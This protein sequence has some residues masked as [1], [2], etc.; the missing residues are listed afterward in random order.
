MHLRLSIILVLLLGLI[1]ESAISASYTEQE[2]QSK[3]A[4]L[5]KLR[6][7][8][9]AIT[10]ERNKV[11]THYDEAQKELR[12]T[13]QRINKLVNEL[14]K[15]DHQLSQQKNKLEKLQQ[16]QHKLHKQLVKQR[17]LLGQQVRAAYMIGRQEYLKLLLNQQDPAILGRTMTY[18]RYFNEARVERIEEVNVTL[19]ELTKV[20]NKIEAQTRVLNEL[21]DDR[22]ASKAMLDK[23]Y[24]K[25]S[26]VIAKLALE[27]KD[28]E[29]KISQLQEDEKQLKKLLKAIEESLPDL[30]NAPSTSKPF[31][32]LRGKLPWPV[33][34]RVKNLYGRSRYQGRIKWNGVLISA[35][36]GKTVHAVSRGRVAYA[37]WLRGY[38]LLLILDHGD[39]YMSLYGHNQ[40]LFKEVGDWV[41]ANEPVGSVGSSGGQSSAGL[42][43][44]IRHNGKPNNP[45]KWCSKTARRS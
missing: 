12:D 1:S 38:G 19:D 22:L 13:E 42:Y 4:E 21:R 20:S 16:Q 39:G 31:A 5:E 11:R 3:S 10:R 6:K 15:I 8:I 27:I 29:M 43:F 28:K 23:S 30:L 45:A 9:Q 37:D 41:E 33:K 18:Y 17:N 36:E 25:R 2:R 34:G 44:E 35:R 32:S 7:R 24:R 40:S 26:E 14:K